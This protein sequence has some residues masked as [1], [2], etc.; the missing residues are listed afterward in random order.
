LSRNLD[1]N[2]FI[3]MARKVLVVIPVVGSVGKPRKLRVFLVISLLI[4]VIALGSF[5]ACAFESMSIPL[6]VKEPLEVLDYP[7]GFSFFPGANVT[8]E[9]TVEN[10]A[11]ITYFVEFDFVLND[12]DYQEKYVAFS[13]YN[14]SIASGTQVLPAWIMVSQSAPPANLMITVNRKTDEPLSSPSPTPV[15]DDSLTPSLKLLGGGARWASPEGKSAL[16]INH[17]DH[18]EAHHLTD[19]VEWG[20]W[21]SEKTMDKWRAGVAA[22][23]EQAGFEV[24]FAGE[25]PED[26]SGYDV[27][28]FEAMWA[29][30]PKHASLVRDYLSNGGGVVIWGSVPCYFS[31]YC[32]DRWPYLVGGTDL[33]SYQDWFGAQTFANT[34]GTATLVV[35]DPFSTGLSL[36]ETVYSGL[37]SEKAVLEL[38]GDSQVIALWE[39]GSV[40]AFTHEYGEGR[41]YYQGEICVDN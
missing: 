26:L 12:T 19:G 8:F 28:V 36:N 16:Y 37:G 24:T 2:A 25:V 35:D 23:L 32:K 1:K 30:E 7:S 40:F 17:K 27:V 6:E 5:A 39:S 10:H 4:S 31:A 38:S 15:F 21:F 18:W 33:S 14:Y 34:C 29:V 13:S 11:P 9:I 3:V 22:T 20:P 41:V